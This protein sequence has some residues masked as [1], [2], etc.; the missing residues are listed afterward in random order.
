[1]ID[2]WIQST[3]LATRPQRLLQRKAWGG[4]RLRRLRTQATLPTQV[5]IAAGL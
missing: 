3:R 4:Q 1:M 2:A 5:S